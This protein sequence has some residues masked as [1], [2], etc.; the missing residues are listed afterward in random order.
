M[1]PRRLLPF[2]FVLAAA[3]HAE[4]VIVTLLATSDLHG[5][6]Y[7]YDYYTG[8]PAQRGLAKIG[9]LI[10][11]ARQENPNSILIDCGDTIQGSPVESVYQGYVR[12]GRLPQALKWNGPV[13]S[14]DPMMVAMNSLGYQAMV[15][16]N[17]EFNFGVK[18]LEKARREANFPWISANIATE[19]G[20]PFQPFQPYVLLSVGGVRVAVIGI[21]TPNIPAWEPPEHYRGLRFLDGVLA[22]Q[23]AVREV[24]QKH[25]PDLVIAAVH[26]GLGSDPRPS[27]QYRPRRAENM[28]FQI[29]RRVAG[30]DAIVYGHSH[31][32][33]DGRLVN[34]VLLV[35]PRNWGTSLAR[36]DF[37]L[38][39]SGSRWK[40]QHKRSRLIPV[41]AQTSA[42]ETVLRLAKPYHELAEAYLDTPIA[43]A[44]SELSGARGRLEDTALVDAIHEVQLHYTK[45]DVSFTALFN[46]QL[47][48]AKGPVTVRQIAAL[49]L[50]DN[51]LY[52]VEGTG[53]MV[54]DALENA[55]RFFLR[56]PTPACDRG[57]LLN[58]SIMGYNFD[59]AQGVS[60]EVDLTKPAGQRIVNLRWKGK[61]LA[62]DQKL[63]IAVNNYRAG[64]SGGYDM[65]RN[66][67]I[68]WRSNEDIRSLIVAYY[69][70]KGRLPEKPDGN[71]RII[72]EAARRTLEAE[73][74]G[75]R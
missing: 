21:T 46:P 30:I 64:G 17:H 14:Q 45:A 20:S 71:W 28:V 37:E 35:Q 41:R 38:A 58:R 8:K 16:G 29:A 43:E 32:Q 63:R 24:R 52:A 23:Q 5:N 48:V 3:V 70:E 67:R 47:R 59:M 54:K 69:L 6:L 36:L 73:L 65:F 57:P 55:A 53:K 26:A 12:L 13:P 40:L 10:R 49:Y 39:R 18:S 44:P 75:A 34:G 15:L 51:D 50:Y 1:R 2:L 31:Q 61:P 60:Y 11:E 62:P 33:E 42:D 72:P 27:S 9:T 56:C 68:V 25:R 66:A 19:P 7:P 22:A 4:T 74:A